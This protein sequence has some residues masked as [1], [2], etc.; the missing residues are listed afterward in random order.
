MKRVCLSVKDLAVLFLLVHLL[1]GV[2]HLTCQ[3][4]PQACVL[5]F[6]HDLRQER[7]GIQ[8]E[9]RRRRRR[10]WTQLGRL[11]TLRTRLGS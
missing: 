8:P 4:A 9:R 10:T 5:L 11:S 7:K 6:L 1:C 3:H 2:R